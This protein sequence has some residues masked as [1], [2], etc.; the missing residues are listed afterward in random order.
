[1]SFR[2][3]INLKQATERSFT[4]FTSNRVRKPLR[5]GKLSG[6]PEVQDGESNRKKNARKMKMGQVEHSESH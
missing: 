2:F 6:H 1:M 5:L 3:E 4:S